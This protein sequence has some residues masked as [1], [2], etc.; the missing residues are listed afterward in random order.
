MD[1]K[2]GLEVEELGQEVEE[3]EREVEELEL[4]VEEVEVEQQRE[5][6]PVE[7]LQISR[8]QL[9]QWAPLH[10]Q[11]MFPVRVGK[12]VPRLPAVFLP[13]EPFC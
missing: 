11:L 13:Q 7:L 1:L 9:P 4:E 3:L 2:L 10:Q 5:E 12:K 8:M 6:V